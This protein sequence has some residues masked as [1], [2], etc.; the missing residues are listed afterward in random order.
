MTTD[1]RPTPNRA[2]VVS[3]AVNR[4]LS[5][6]LTP[7]VRARALANRRARAEWARANL[8]SDF[9]DDPRWVDLARKRGLRLPAWTAIC[10]RSAMVR[11]LHRLGLSMDWYREQNGYRTVEQ[12]IEANPAWP[13]RA[14]VGLCLEDTEGKGGGQ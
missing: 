11:W 14:F 12:W 7:E 2:E 9:L 6:H 3:G 13:L 8:R 4:S 1:T 10:T 5:D